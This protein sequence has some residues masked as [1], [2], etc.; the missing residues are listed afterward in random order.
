MAEIAGIRRRLA[1]LLYESLLL[2]GVLGFGFI[3]P[4]VLIGLAAHWTPP[5]WLEWLHIAVL[6]GFYFIVLWRRNGQT[7]A[8]Q[9]WRLQIIDTRTRR[10]P[11]L[12]QCLIRYALAWPSVCFFGAGLLWAWFDRDNQFLHDRFSDTCVVLLLQS[13]PD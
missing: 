10:P 2:L 12:K 11:D 8:M 13:R 9:T 1:S 3:L 7:L 4:L 6:L 5:G